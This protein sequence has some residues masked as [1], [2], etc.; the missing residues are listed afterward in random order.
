MAHFCVRTCMTVL[1][2]STPRLHASLS[3]SLCIPASR[4]SSFHS[5]PPSLD[6]LFTSLFPPIS[7]TIYT[8]FYTLYTSLPIS[9]FSLAS[10]SIPHFSLCSLFVRLCLPSVGTDMDLRLSPKDSHNTILS[11]RSICYKC[12][13]L[14]LDLQV[15]CIIPWFGLPATLLQRVS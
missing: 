3:L 10:F 13:E 11:L 14:L 1:V 9:L 12:L 6:S 15:G 8:L 7:Y 5:L 2:S 4:S